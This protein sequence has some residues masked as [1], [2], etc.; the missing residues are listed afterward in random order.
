MATTGKFRLFGALI[1]GAVA[2]GMTSAARADVLFHNTT[3]HTVFFSVTCD[4]N[5]VDQW[6]LAPYGN[7]SLVCNNGA[8]EMRV[9]IKTA[10]GPD[11]VTVRATVWDGR[12]YNLG[13]DGD[14]DVSIASRG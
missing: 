13:Y 12:T 10:H 7:R 2:V 9:F 14:G 4:G 3:G 1:A 8:P 6:T 5:G 11:T